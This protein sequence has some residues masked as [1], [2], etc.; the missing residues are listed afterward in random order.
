MRAEQEAEKKDRL[1]LFEE[2]K[3]LRNDQEAQQAERRLLLELLGRMSGSSS[4]S[5]FPPPAV[6]VVSSEQLNKA[7]AAG[8][9][10]EEWGCAA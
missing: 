9:A 3:A 2:L 7:A 6:G 4:E 5:A 1:K 8:R 10:L